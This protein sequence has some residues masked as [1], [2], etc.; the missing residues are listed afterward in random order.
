M[1]A[2]I[3]NMP[4][5]SHQLLAHHERLWVPDC[6]NYTIEPVDFAEMLFTNF[7][8]LLRIITLVRVSATTLLG[9]FETELVSVKEDD[10]FWIVELGSNASCQPNGPGTDDGDSAAG[11]HEAA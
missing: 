11:L 5:D 2:Y 8:C 1:H 10:L 7:P 9:Y 4:A 3:R 6:L